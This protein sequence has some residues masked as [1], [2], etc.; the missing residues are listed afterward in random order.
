[1][2]TPR[3]LIVL[4]LVILAAAAF[5]ATK[6][7]ESSQVVT[8]AAATRPVMVNLEIL[9]PT[10]TAAPPPTTTTVPPT[11]TTTRRATPP[12]TA[13]PAPMRATSASGS[14]SG[15]PDDP[16]SWDRL[17]QCESGG[18]WHIATGNGYWGGLQFSLSSWRAVGGTGYPHEH[19][20]E[21]QILRGRLLWAQGGWRHWPGCTRSF[22]WI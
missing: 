2:S 10:T 18:D 14:G 22:G 8:A 21:E 12:T 15:N 3:A 11:T 20:R 19:S 1:M 13:P 5:L 17:A 4:V 6:P 9:S 7:Q 16:A